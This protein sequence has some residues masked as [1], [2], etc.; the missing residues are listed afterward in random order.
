LQYFGV[1]SALLPRSMDGIH[2]QRKW[3]E[4]ITPY[5]SIFSLNLREIWNYRDLLLILIRRDILAIYKQTILGPL[6]FFLQ[7][8]LVTITFM[9][10]FSRVAKL[11]TGG[12]PPLL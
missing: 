9:I 1:S 2:E 4:I 5:N 7:P 3:R 12:M 11:P 8:I 6:W 10:G